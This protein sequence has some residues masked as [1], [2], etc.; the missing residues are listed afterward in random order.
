VGAI[1]IEFEVRLTVGNLEGQANAE[2]VEGWATRAHS[3]AV[4]V[5][6]TADATAGLLE[7]T[8]MRGRLQGA[9]QHGRR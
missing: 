1:G 9:G 3:A 2:S 4:V 7:Q 5:R 8:A 6:P